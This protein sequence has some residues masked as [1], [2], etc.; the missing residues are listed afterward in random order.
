MQS[1][2]FLTCITELLMALEEIRN[3]KM[4]RVVRI[5]VSENECLNIWNENPA[6]G[7]KMK[8]NIKKNR[9]ST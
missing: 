3:K 9:L 1:S 8:Q 7:K 2:F 5:P 6:V 4:I